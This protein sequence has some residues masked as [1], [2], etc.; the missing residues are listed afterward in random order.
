M[1]LMTADAPAGDSTQALATDVDVQTALALTRA[2]ARTL[3]SLSPQIQQEMQAAL[4]DEIALQQARGGQV[5][6]LVAALLRDHLREA[7]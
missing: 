4:H 2:V 7:A 3:M 1:P 5:P 6:D